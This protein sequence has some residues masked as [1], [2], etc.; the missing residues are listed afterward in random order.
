MINA[1]RQ[2]RSTLPHIILHCAP[3][4][5]KT[6]RSQNAIGALR[7]A[8]MQRS[9]FNRCTVCMMIAGFLAPSAELERYRNDD[10]LARNALGKRRERRRALDSGYCGLI[11]L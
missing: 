7:N 11:K 4:R 10:G 8:A 9:E 2:T 3:R 6:N 1:P 5:L